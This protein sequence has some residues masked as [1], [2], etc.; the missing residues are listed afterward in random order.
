MGVGACVNSV[1]HLELALES[2]F[3]P[4]AIQ[5]S[6][7]GLNRADMERVARSGIRINVDSIGQLRQWAS[8]GGT[9]AGLRVNARSLSSDRPQDRIGM[10]LQDVGVAR[11]L[12][13]ELSVKVRGLHIYIGTNIQSHEGLVPAMSRLFTLAEQF[14]HLR[15]LNIGG[16]VGVN[17]SHQGPEFDLLAYGRAVADCRERLRQNTGVEALVIL[18]PGR[19]LTASCAKLLARVTDV[20]VLGGRRYVAVDA[21]VAIFPRPF[22]HPD[23]PHRIWHLSAGMARGK[24]VETVVVGRTTFSGDILG[25]ALLPEDLEVG[26]VLVFDDAGSYS[27]SMAS[28]F[29]GQPPPVITTT[30]VSWVQ[31]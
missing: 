2:G 26:D 17:Y 9:E 7:T 10:D 4:E 6:S 11:A 25:P 24:H 20:K 8:L 27:Q 14:P 23:S 12:A 15:Y 30:D 13:S 3:S 31:R 29:L 1:P 16:G 18:E 5:Y 28:R 21:S 19:R 22:H